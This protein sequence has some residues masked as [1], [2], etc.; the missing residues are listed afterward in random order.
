MVIQ[1]LQSHLHP[2]M[3]YRLL[4]LSFLAHYKL[5]S[6]NKDHGSFLQITNQHNLG[7]EFLTNAKASIAMDFYLVDF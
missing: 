5:F 4:H 7:L 2:V 1:E 3:S 6:I